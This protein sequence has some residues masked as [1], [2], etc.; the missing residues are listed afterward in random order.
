M[1]GTKNGRLLESFKK[2]LKKKEQK[3]KQNQKKNPQKLK[4]VYVFADLSE[5]LQVRCQVRVS[6]AQKGR[7]IL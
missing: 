6:S 4:I 3:T 5:A 1:Q 2:F 7:T